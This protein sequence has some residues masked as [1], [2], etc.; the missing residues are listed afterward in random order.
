MGLLCHV[1]FCLWICL[2]VNLRLLVNLKPGNTYLS[3]AV[4]L[5]W[6]EFHVIG[7]S[8]M[9]ILQ[10][11][12]RKTCWQS[13]PFFLVWNKMLPTWVPVKGFLGFP[14]HPFYFSKPLAPTVIKKTPDFCCLYQAC[15]EVLIILHL[16]FLVW[17]TFGKGNLK[18]SGPLVQKK[19]RDKSWLNSVIYECC[20]QKQMYKSKLPFLCI[21]VISTE[22]YLHVCTLNNWSFSPDNLKCKYKKQEKLIY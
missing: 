15:L 18:K 2:L 8:Q 20:R 5:C 4:F 3:S 9:E 21:S 1:R 22:Y 10:Q 13:E 6:W 16:W 14:A 7:H 12:P 19:K 11:V 17:F